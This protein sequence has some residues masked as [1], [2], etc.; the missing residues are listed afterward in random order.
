M[1]NELDNSIQKKGNNKELQNTIQE[2]RKNVF[3][4]I[5]NIKTEGE[6]LRLRKEKLRKIKSS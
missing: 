5:R 3:E 6:I 1:L 4:T 2:H